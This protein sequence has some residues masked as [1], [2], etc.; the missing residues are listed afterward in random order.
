M[1]VNAGLSHNT[2]CGFV[3]FQPIPVKILVQS[4]TFLCMI[5][6]CFSEWH[7]KK[8]THVQKRQQIVRVSLGTFH[9][10]HAL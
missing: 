9:E 1:K 5:Q 7:P 6:F 8:Y 10:A 4:L 2:R 3:P